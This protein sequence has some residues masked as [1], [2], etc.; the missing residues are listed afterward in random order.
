MMTIQKNSTSNE[1]ND[2]NSNFSTFLSSNDIEIPLIQRDYVQGSNKQS[3]KRDAFIDSLFTAILDP[4]QPCELDFIY[5]TYDHGAFMPLDGQQ[6]LTTLYL[7][8]WFLSNK[9][10]LEKASEFSAINNSYLDTKSFNYKTRRSS[11][12]FCEKLKSFKPSELSTIISEDIKGQ[13]WFSENW[14]QD[15]SVIA[16]LEMLDA[17]N[18]KYLSLEN[19]DVVQMYERLVNTEAINFDHLDMGTYKLTDSLYVKMNAR[20]KQLTVFENWKAKFIQYLEDYYDIQEYSTPADDRKEDFN[21]IKNY[22][23]HSIEHEWTDLFWTYAVNDYKIRLA[24]YNKL[25]EDEK[26][27]KP[28]PSGPLIDSYFLNFYYYIYRIQFFLTKNEEGDEDDN[29]DKPINGTEAS[30]KLLFKNKECLEFLY[31]S[32]D[33]FV[34]ISINNNRDIKHFFNEL[35]Y[36]IGQKVDGSVRLFSSNN[37][38]LFKLT[39]S[40]KASVD[41][42]ILLFC[43]IKYCIKNKCYTVTDE[44]K[45]YARVCRN[46]LESITQR[47]TKDMKMHSNVR[48]SHLPK[49]IETI[50]NLCSVKNVV[51]LSSFKAG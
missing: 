33:L 5:G 49:Y 4:E 31:S 13:T 11:T 27:T 26:M 29:V 19:P 41:E 6:R 16:M 39:I 36:L 50:D 20:G 21:K 8:H 7:L 1:A 15:P 40:N 23:T 32:L 14:K 2:V 28:E 43:V 18:E 44:L 12:A 17:L 48:F 37:V 47:L 42:Q 34:E 46:M 35:F 24:E 25:T 9:C 30:R 51:M 45:K 22:F 10:R 3:E 38:D